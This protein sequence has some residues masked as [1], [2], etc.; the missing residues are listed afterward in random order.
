MERRHDP[1]KGSTSYL[2]AISPHL[3]LWKQRKITFRLRLGLQLLR[4]RAARPNQHPHQLL[5]LKM[6]LLQGAN[7]QVFG[8]LFPSCAKQTALCPAP[9]RTSSHP[10]TMVLA[11]CRPCPVLLPRLTT[12]PQPRQCPGAG[13]RCCLRAACS[14][15]GEHTVGERKPRLLPV[16]CLYTP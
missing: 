10:L 14:T 8:C 9:P 5:C 3:A 11:R 6:P 1:P 4:P 13:Q 2:P 16:S 7:F 15:E 12:D